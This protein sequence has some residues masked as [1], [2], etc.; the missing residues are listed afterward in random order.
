MDKIHNNLKQILVIK[1][2]KQRKL[3]K[4]TDLS[5]HTVFS[6]CNHRDCNVSSAIKVA[7]A[8]KIS[9]D[10]LFNEKLKLSS[11]EVST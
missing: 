8:L 11:S 4:L 1:G 5:I 6:M 3:A 10:T 7:K 9:L 2:I